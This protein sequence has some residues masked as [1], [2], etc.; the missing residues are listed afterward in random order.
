MRG[1]RFFQPFS[2]GS[3]NPCCV[4]QHDLIQRRTEPGGRS[5][6]PPA[7]ESAAASEAAEPS[8][9]AGA[10][11]TVRLASSPSTPRS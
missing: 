8:E 2:L 4:R 10:E 5:T 7:S 1:S 9:A 6:A 11:E 3:L